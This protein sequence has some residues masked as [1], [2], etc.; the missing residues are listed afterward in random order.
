M[1]GWTIK[2]LNKY[3]WEGKEL[4][5]YEEPDGSKII[6]YLDKNEETSERSSWTKMVNH[7]ED[8]PA[9]I[10]GNCRSYYLHGQWHS[11]E[12]WK[13]EMEKIIEGEQWYASNTP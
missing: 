6:V 10:K 5:L 9:Y 4:H 7:C 1:I 8:G 3:T 2:S 13:Q 12:R 11:E